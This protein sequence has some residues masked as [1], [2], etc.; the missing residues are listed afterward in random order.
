[1]DTRQLII[2]ISEKLKRGYSF[3]SI[4]A[5]LLEHNW[6]AEQI[7]T[8]YS[9]CKIP[10]K[11]NS[12]VLLNEPIKHS[13]FIVFSLF[14]F[15]FVFM[16]GFCVIQGNQNQL[17][18]THAYSI[19]NPQIQQTKILLFGDMML[20]REVRAK[21]NA[22]GQ[23]YPFENIKNFIA[24]NNI[25]VANAEG[26]FS[27]FNSKTLG[28]KNAP[29]EFTFDTAMLSVL[30]NL[31]FTLL[32]Q[33]NNHSLNF[34]EVGLAQSTTSITLAG[35][36]YFGDPSNIDIHPY[37]QEIH[38]E[39]I[40]FV[41]YNEFSH[42]GLDNVISTIKDLRNQVSFLIVYPHWG[43]E[44][45]PTFSQSQQTTAHAFIDAGADVVI[46]MHPHVIEP[47]EIYNGKPI[48]YSIG[49]FIFDQNFSHSTSQGLA[50]KI[51]LEKNDVDYQLFPFSIA[52]EQ[53]SL[54]NVS[55][56]QSILYSLSESAVT[57]DD[58]KAE[59][60]SG[61]IKIAR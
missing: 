33:A 1:M 49:N 28:V 10:Q 61:V 51:L 22:N 45:S 19:S 43:V 60:A 5:E 54:M 12:F 9:M 58:E 8:A 55:D 4:K 23:E 11:T 21:I 25:V 40:G 32:G 13:Q 39:K 38:G 6:Q 3:E 15:L 44:Y 24:G 18:I 59:I 16:L 30:K 57:N 29:L 17:A 56:T 53:A 26:I 20:D 14:S 2:Y 37:V 41:A 36:H 47:I 27:F 34:G 50:V 35:L 31:G 7:Q 46:G 48:F 52:E 42:Q